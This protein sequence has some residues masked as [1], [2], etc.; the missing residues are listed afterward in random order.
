MHIDNNADKVII[1][2]LGKGAKIGIVVAVV[3]ALA[4]GIP[5]AVIYWPEQGGP[6]DDF[7]L[8]LTGYGDTVNVTYADLTDP[9]KY[10]QVTQ[11]Y[12][13]INPFGSE[14]SISVKGVLLTT[15]IEDL[16]L[17][18]S[19]VTGYK[20]VATDGFDTAYMPL[21]YLNAAPDQVL[22]GWEE[23]GVTLKSAAEDGDGPLRAYVNWSFN[24]P[25]PNDPLC[26]KYLAKVEFQSKTEFNFTIYGDGI[27]D[28][29]VT[30]SYQ[31]MLSA[32]RFFGSRWYT[33]CGD[34][35]YTKTDGGTSYN[36][37]GAPLYGLINRSA[38]LRFLDSYDNWD[39]L[40][41]V[42]STGDKSPWLS[43]DEISNPPTNEDAILLAWEMNDEPV[44]SGYFTSVV[45]STVTDPAGE[46]WL[47][48]VVGIEL[49]TT[50]G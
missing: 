45:N 6:Y 20:F 10:E 27:L 31:T 40:R 30:L 25:V 17:D 9:N 48:D 39:E 16:E 26:S 28:E 21:S 50:V 44:A 29:N 8:S 35:E 19:S 15:L 5:L 2:A 46:Y 49:G 38:G 32:K 43:K 11:D 12:Y 41:F 3:A 24:K 47:D 18:L 36:F 1:M 33:Y 7:E 22:I 42:N 4:I 34:Y 13:F 37:T 23:N 14:E